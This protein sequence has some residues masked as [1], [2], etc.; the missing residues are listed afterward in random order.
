MC[1]DPH[2]ITHEYYVLPLLHTKLPD[3]PVPEEK[4]SG[5]EST[6][7]VKGIEDILVAERKKGGGGSGSVSGGGGSVNGA[8]TGAARSARHGSGLG[9]NGHAPPAV[10]GGGLMGGHFAPV[11]K[12]KFKSKPI[13]S[14][15]T[16]LINRG[17][18]HSSPSNAPCPDRPL[19]P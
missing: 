14:E 6:S 3:A 2:A 5:G 8:A 10:S 11:N 7:V 13:F 19:T 16:I 12:V 9:L 18:L 17:L 4:S 1:T 15:S